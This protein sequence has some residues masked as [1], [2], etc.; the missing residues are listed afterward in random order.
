LP[1]PTALAA[2]WPRWRTSAVTIYGRTVTAQVFDC[3]ALWY[4]ALRD[5]P[6][7]LVVVRDPAGTRK[8][9]AFCCTEG[10]APAHFVL[11]AYARRWTLAG[12]V[13]DAKQ[14]LGF[15]DPQRQAAR[16]V[17]RSAPGA[18]SVDD[19]ILLWAAHQAQAGRPVQPVRRPW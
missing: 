6:V 18:G 5:H 17:L 9:E 19:L 14:Y 8:D 12:T 7:R 2:A 10:G 13:H 4:V 15:G 1:T 16:A 3:R 11:E